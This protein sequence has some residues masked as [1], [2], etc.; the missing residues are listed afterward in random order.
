[1]PI[2]AAILFV[3]AALPASAWEFRPDPVCTL[4]HDT[5][6]ARVT[7]TFDAAQP[8]YTLEVELFSGTWLPSD[9]FGVLFAGPLGLTIG[10]DRHVIDGPRLTVTD[11]GFGNVLNGLQYNRMAR[12]YTRHQAVDVPLDGAGLAVARFRDCP[13]APGV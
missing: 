4:W 3:L 2:R 6:E 12:A 13:A 1:M 5:D 7:V 10:T 11:T 8:L 9:R